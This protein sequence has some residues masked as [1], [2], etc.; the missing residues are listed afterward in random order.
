MLQIIP[1]YFVSVRYL[2]IFNFSSCALCSN[3]LQ[4]FVLKVS[5]IYNPYIIISSQLI[6][7]TSQLQQWYKRIKIKEQILITSLNSLI[8]N[9]PR[10]LPLRLPIPNLLSSLK[11]P[12]RKNL[13]SAGSLWNTVTV[14]TKKDA[15]SPTARINYWETIN[16]I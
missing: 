4:F 7:T 11:K 14:P 9:N 3:S 2:L 13:N 8:K 1:S 5:S 16:W 10:Q 15:N 6:L 12:K